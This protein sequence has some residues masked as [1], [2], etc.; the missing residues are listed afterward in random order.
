M[1]SQ[2]TNQ[3]NSGTIEIQTSGAAAL[4]TM[5]FQATAYGAPDGQ[6]IAT[7]NGLPLEDTNAVAG[8]ATQA[9]QKNSSAGVIVQCSVGLPA[10]GEDIELSS[11]TFDTG[12]TVRLTDLTYECSD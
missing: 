1:T 10:S 4:A 8:T 5:T 12:D 2:V 3:L 9:Q 6:A 11:L 7:A